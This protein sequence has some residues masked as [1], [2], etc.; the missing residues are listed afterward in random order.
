[1]RL[2]QL[3]FNDIS[4]HKSKRCPIVFIFFSH[5]MFSKTGTEE[6]ISTLDHMLKKNKVARDIISELK[7][8]TKHLKAFGILDKVR[9]SQLAMFVTS[10]D[11]FFFL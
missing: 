2:L 6:I 10:T 4:Q 7:S 5:L 1:M 11:I 3:Y 9:I 8:M